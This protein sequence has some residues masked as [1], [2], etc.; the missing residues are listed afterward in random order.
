MER[1]AFIIGEDFIYWSA[2]ILTL[3]AASA[4]CV[5]VALYLGKS[6]NGVAAAMA[7]PLSLALSLVLARLVHWYCRTDSYE[8]FFCGHDGLF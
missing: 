8:S 1:S 5:F 6:G 4:A 7:V 3:A 2:I